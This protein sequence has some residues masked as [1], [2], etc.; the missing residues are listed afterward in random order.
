[1]SWVQLALGG[2][3]LMACSESCRISLVAL[4]RDSANAA[5]TKQ[6][7]QRPLKTNAWDLSWI[8]KEMME[9]NRRNEI[10]KH[11]CEGGIRSGQSWRLSISLLPCIMIWG[12]KVTDR[13]QKALI[14]LYIL[15]LARSSS[16][17]QSCST[18]P[19][20]N[21]EVSLADISPSTE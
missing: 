7:S 12:E 5:T 13:P 21:L 10:Y 8:T 1:M 15:T 16:V 3:N 6:P 9:K 14:G 4:G 20:F 18:S 2:K 11:I 19:S 17:N